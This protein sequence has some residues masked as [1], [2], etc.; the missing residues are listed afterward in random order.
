MHTTFPKY[1]VALAL[2]IRIV[3]FS[4]FRRVGIVCLPLRL[5]FSFTQ[6]PKVVITRLQY[7]KETNE[8]GK[9]C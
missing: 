2:I 4:L 3:L 7:I 9:N 6:H 5:I 8:L 1:V